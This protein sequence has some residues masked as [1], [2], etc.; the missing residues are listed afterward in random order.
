MSRDII[1]N[2]RV[3]PGVKVGFATSVATL[4]GTTWA[5]AYLK[6]KVEGERIQWEGVQVQVGEALAKV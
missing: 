4:E 2:L 3:C 1:T 5:L 6:S